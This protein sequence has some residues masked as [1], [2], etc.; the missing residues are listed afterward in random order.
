MPKLERMEGFVNRMI[1]E[2]GLKAKVWSTLD[3]K[4]AVKDAKYIINMINVG[5]TDAFGM[6]YSIPMEFGVDQCIG[7]SL[8]PGG[9][10]RG[11]RTFP[12]LEGLLSE[13]KELSD[14]DAIFLN[15]TNPMGAVC[16]GI[17]TLGQTP[18]VGLCHGVQTTLDL[19]SSYTDT[20]KDQIDYLCAGINHMDWFLKLSDKRNGRDLNP[21]L[22][23]RMEKPEYY[24]NE[25]VR[26]E[27]MRHFGYFM[28]ES[29]G[30]LS[31]YIPWFRSH[32]RALDL[33]CDMP[34]SRGRKRGLL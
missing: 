9:V 4:A 8:G 33:Y 31:E 20:P 7:D 6:D 18:Y 11:L 12:V 13:I 29:T 19:I 2:N 32:K 16:H 23:E 10:F 17:G 26:G 25:K 34:D 14:P 28:T 5:G 24:V 30:H 15:Y 21:I 27:V 3:R 22:R 1:T